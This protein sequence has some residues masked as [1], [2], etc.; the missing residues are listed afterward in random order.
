M[1]AITDTSVPISLL[2]LTTPC[3]S[4][5]GIFSLGGTVETGPKLFEIEFRN[6]H[7]VRLINVMIVKKETTEKGKKRS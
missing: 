5:F 7:P 1:H 2:N 4:E 3:Q 6:G